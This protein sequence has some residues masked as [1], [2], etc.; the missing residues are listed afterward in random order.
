MKQK[1]IFQKTKLAKG[2][3]LAVLLGGAANAVAG[4]QGHQ[5]GPLMTLGKTSNPNTLLSLANNPAGAELL[6]AEDESLRMGY[7]SSLGMGFE[8]GNLN[9][10]VDDIEELEEILE[11]DN[12]GI[13]EAAEAEEKFSAL[14]PKLGEDFNMAWDIGVHIPFFPIAIRSDWLGGVV[15]LDLSTSMLA[16]I[17]FLDKPIEISLTN[18]GDYEA[19]T[20][21][22]LYFKAGNLVTGTVGYG[23]EVWQPPVL[24]SKL[25]AGANINVYH[26]TLNKQ[27]VSFQAAADSDDEIGDIV[28][29]ELS[30]NTIST[31]AVGVDLGLLWKFTNAEVG[32]TITNIN[33][34]EFDYGTLGNDC[35]QYEGLRETNCNASLAF[36]DEI[37][38]NEKAV[39]NAQSTLSGSLHTEDKMFLISGAYDV[40][41]AYNIVGRESQMVSAAV[42][43]FPNSYIIPTLRLSAQKNLVGSELTV[44]GFGTTLFGMMNIDL[45]ASLDTIEYDDQKLPRYIG[46]NIGFEEK[47]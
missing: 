5:P 17:R 29:D 27:V 18:D 10:V 46:F 23:R 3:A 26:A 47:F 16:D 1:I 39:L 43:Y 25:Y 6:I 42:S 9:N 20:D 12:L 37:N 14:L 45:S 32:L 31:T 21:S 30:E 7:W 19:T 22:A 13:N 40:N 41:S 4:F 33:E 15:S 35:S 8:L 34:P 11:N 28:S 36:Q 2:V 44:V 24:D 38:L